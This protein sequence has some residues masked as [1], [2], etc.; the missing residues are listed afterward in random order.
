VL[1]SPV[2]A[3]AGR[4]VLGDAVEAAEETLDG[5]AASCPPEVDAVLG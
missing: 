5:P 3:E 1:L 4:D 2:E